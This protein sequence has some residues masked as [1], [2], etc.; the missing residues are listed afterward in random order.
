MKGNEILTHL[1]LGVIKLT[2][3]DTRKIVKQPADK[4]HT[5]KSL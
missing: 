4:R 5:G 2:E 1:L 3:N